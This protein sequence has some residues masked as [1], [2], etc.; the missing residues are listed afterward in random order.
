MCK[1]KY[2][3]KQII[4]YP[5]TGVVPASAA[6]CLTPCCYSVFVFSLR[7]SGLLLRL[8]V[9]PALC[10]C[11]LRCGDACSH[12]TPP[13]GFLGHTRAGILSRLAGAS[14][15][16]SRDPH[17]GSRDP[18]I[19]TIGHCYRARPVRHDQTLSRGAHRLLQ[20]PDLTAR[21]RPTEQTP[22]WLAV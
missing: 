9:S 11:C 18:N 4:Q 3:D 6:A 12:S 13:S 8:A 22:A 21:E 15:S 19:H 17:S 1:Q 20:T 16:G 2:N 14:H 10:C 5:R 7:R